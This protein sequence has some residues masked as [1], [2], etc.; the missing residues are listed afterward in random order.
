MSGELDEN[1]HGYY[2]ECNSRRAFTKIEG[3]TLMKRAV[4]AISISILALIAIILVFWTHSTIN[5]RKA[6]LREDLDD[7]VLIDLWSNP[8]IAINLRKE[9]VEEDFSDATMVIALSSNS[10]VIKSRVCRFV[11]MDKEDVVVSYG[12]RAAYV[13]GLVDGMNG[14]N[15]EVK[16][17][18]FMGTIID[19]SEIVLDATEYDEIIELAVETVSEDDHV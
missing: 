1:W 6:M 8:F 2:R 3:R 4:L 17:M 10:S 19:E 18:S 9:F 15:L 12:T 13:Y 16:S 7:N 11:F 5:K 14:M